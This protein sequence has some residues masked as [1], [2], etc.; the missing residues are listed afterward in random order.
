MS[1]IINPGT[2]PVWP[3]TRENAEACVRQFIV[4][5]KLPGVTYENV[6]MADELHDD[7][8]GRFA[9]DL[10]RGDRKCEIAIPGLPVEEVRYTD[11]KT[12]NSLAYPRMYVEGNSWLWLYALGQAGDYLGDDNESGGS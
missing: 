9:F 11:P 7:F 3:A 2:G 4:D 12:E 1:V 5:L 6:V 10:H 8:D